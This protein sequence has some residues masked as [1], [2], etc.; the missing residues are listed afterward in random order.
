MNSPETTLP[1]LGQFIS[2]YGD[3]TPALQDCLHCSQ[4]AAG[5]KLVIDA[6]NN[7]M[8][9][10]FD[11]NQLATM[12]PIAIENHAADL[13]VFA[14]LQSVPPGKD[15][16]IQFKPDSG[17]KVSLFLD[18]A[19]MQAKLS[20]SF[21]LAKSSIAEVYTRTQGSTCQQVFD[22]T[23]HR[24]AQARFFG[25]TETAAEQVTG[26][27]VHVNHVE[28]DNLTDQ[29]YYSYASGTSAIEFTGKIT[30]QPGA[31]GSVAH[32]LHRGVALTQ[33]ARISAQPFLNI[34]HDDVRCT[35]GSTVGFVN[36]D[37]LH[38]LRARGIEK[39]VAE[40][41]LI[42]SSQRQFYEAIPAEIASA[43][44]NYEGVEI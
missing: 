20:A 17:T 3:L 9:L 37:A 25:L 19:E 13:Q 1:A 41:L 2:N 39:S 15:V 38:Y 10:I 5:Y 36:A 21:D 29:K 33:G 35:H 31:D 11:G 22:A 24:G 16:T 43:F 32:Q 6:T 23:V 4:D 18:L 8:R 26:I 12:G 42:Q 28:G 40:M 14:K 44:Y 30:V 7:S 27:H 34:K